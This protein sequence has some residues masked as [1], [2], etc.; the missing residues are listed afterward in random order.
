VA[1]LEDL[2]MAAEE[3]TV[4]VSLTWADCFRLR[5]HTAATVLQ[6]QNI[7]CRAVNKHA[8]GQLKMQDDAA[9]Q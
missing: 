1:D 9:G 5:C 6:R 2:E 4:A 7:L 8:P 3:A